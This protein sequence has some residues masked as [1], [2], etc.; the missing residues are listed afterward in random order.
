MKH[1]GS[2]IYIYIVSLASA[3]FAE[4]AY[5]CLICATHHD[6]VY[7]SDYLATRYQQIVDLFAHLLPTSSY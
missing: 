6:P 3:S 2:A 1:W 5:M 4:S 7:K